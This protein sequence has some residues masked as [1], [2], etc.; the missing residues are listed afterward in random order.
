MKW[1]HWQTGGTKL[2]LI[3]TGYKMFENV[4]NYSM[5]DLEIGHMLKFQNFVH[6]QLYKLTDKFYR[7]SDLI[8]NYLP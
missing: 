6:L 1:C 7:S 8:W 5:T 3:L 4:E 2:D